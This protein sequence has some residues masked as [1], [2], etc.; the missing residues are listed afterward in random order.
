MDLRLTGNALQFAKQNLTA[1]DFINFQQLE[2]ET[3][4]PYND[5]IRSFK[6]V[7]AQK[8]FL[9]SLFNH[10]FL[11]YII[12]TS[13][14]GRGYFKPE[15]FGGLSSQALSPNEV[16]MILYN[17]SHYVYKDHSTN[18]WRL[19]LWFRVFMWCVGARR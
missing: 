13:A 11:R 2:L 9:I 19:R 10:T 15:E 7:L 12:W 5:T 8:A 14:A 17:N 16:D 4:V 3:K 6:T 18:L 1:K